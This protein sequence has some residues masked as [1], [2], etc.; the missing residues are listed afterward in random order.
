M[1]IVFLKYLVSPFVIFTLSIAQEPSA[2]PTPTSVPKSLFTPFK[3]I[4]LWLTQLLSVVLLL[5]AF[6][7]QLLQPLLLVFAL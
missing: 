2:F 7:L 4:A 3:T 5:F 1:F 6:V